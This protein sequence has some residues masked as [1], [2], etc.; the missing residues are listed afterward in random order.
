MVSEYLTNYIWGPGKC[1]NFQTDKIISLISTQ[2][3]VFY[4]S[5]QAKIGDTPNMLVDVKLETNI[6]DIL[7]TF[8]SSG[9]K[10]TFKK[11]DSMKIL[12]DLLFF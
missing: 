2:F 10:L 11:F 1:L 6:S 12:Q 4:K 8:K 3:L 9:V 7:K 5:F